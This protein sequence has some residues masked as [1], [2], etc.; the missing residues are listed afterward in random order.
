MEQ[1]SGVYGQNILG[2]QAKGNINDIQSIMDL[3]EKKPDANPVDGSDSFSDREIKRESMR[4][5]N[6]SAQAGG[7]LGGMLTSGGMQAGLMGAGPVG[8]GVMG[9][10]LL[11]SA[12]ENNK[13]EKA[14]AEQ[15]AIN[16]EMNRRNNLMSLAKDSA[17]SSFRL[18]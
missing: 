3:F 12:I 7:G 5:A 17:N 6:S 2:S 18:A 9:G 11:L 14:A 10:G 4:A 15:T 8:W 13:K 1:S 16:N